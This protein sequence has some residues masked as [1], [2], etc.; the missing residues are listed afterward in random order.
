MFRRVLVPVDLGKKAHRAVGA[1]ARLAAPSRAQLTLLHV[2]ERVDAEAPEA[3]AGFYRKLERMARDRLRELSA[4]L[5]KQNLRVRT[6]ISYGKP[7][8]EILR[9]AGESGSDLIVMS[10][11]KLRLRHPGENWGTISYK[12]GILSRCPVLLVK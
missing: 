11:H 8:N 12:V 5:A 1:A 7:V 2:I 6:Q 3:F 9:F 10:S 4:P